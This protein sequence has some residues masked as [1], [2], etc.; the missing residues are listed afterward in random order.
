MK[1]I[2]GFLA[3][4]AILAG[5]AQTESAPGEEARTYSAHFVS[6]GGSAVDPVIG[7]ASGSLIPRP[8]DPQRSGYDFTE[9]DR[10]EGLTVPWNF[11]TDTVTGDVTLYAKWTRMN[12]ATLDVNAA[13][14]GLSPGFQDGDGLDAVTGNLSLATSAGEGVSVSWSS[15]APG[16]VT[17]DG[18]VTRPAEGSP[19][20]AVRLTATLEKDTASAQKTFDLTVLAMGYTRTYTLTFS[21]DGGSPVEPITDIASG[22]SVA[23]P[24]NPSK[25]GYAFAGWFT[26]AELTVALGSDAVLVSADLTLYAKWT[27]LAGNRVTYVAEGASPETVP[28]DTAFYSPGDYFMVKAT[29]PIREG[30]SFLGWNDAYDGSGANY[31]QY[32]YY[33]FPASGG[34]V[35]Y[36]QWRRVITVTYEAPDATEGSVP[37][38]A[39]AYYYPSASYIYVKSNT[40]FLYRDGYTLAGWTLTEDGIGTVYAAGDGVEVPDAPV[41]FYARWTEGENDVVYFPN[42]ATAGAV[43]VDKADYAAG[44]TVSWTSQGTLKKDDLVFYGWNTEADGTGTLVTAKDPITFGGTSIKLYAQWL[45]ASDAINLTDSGFDASANGFTW[46]MAYPD[47]TIAV[48]SDGKIVLGEKI[49]VDGAFKARILRLNA[50]GSLDAGFPALDLGFTG[51][52][53]GTVTTGKARYVRTLSDDRF[54]AYG[55]YYFVNG[56]PVQNWGNLFSSD[57]TVD[58]SY[59]HGDYDA[60]SGEDLSFTGSVY[61]F[62]DDSILLGGGKT[63]HPAEY[64][65]R[66]TPSGEVDPTFSFYASKPDYKPNAYKNIRILADSKFMAIE[67]L[68]QGDAD[69]SNDV[70]RI[71]RFT[72]DGS[73]D[74]S[75]APYELD[76]EN[77]DKQNFEV[78]SSG[79]VYAAIN[80]D[81]GTTQTLM[82]IRLTAAGTID[83]TYGVPSWIDPFAGTWTLL[84]GT[85]AFFPAVSLTTG[86]WSS[87]GLLTNEDGTI[88]FTRRFTGNP[89]VSVSGATMLNFGDLGLYAV[90]SSSIKRFNLDAIRN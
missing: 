45:E 57:G 7:L 77:A 51:Y 29:T 83:E 42:G 44:D 24:E 2:L 76:Q 13:K 52:P 74:A 6:N 10:D 34:V 64:F 87:S 47:S 32:Y 62:P 73:L 20:A 60:V 17:N 35:L 38:D 90:S 84:D 82:L 75:F 31:G 25:A 16:T 19:N 28:V 33:T 55:Y 39:N 11:E 12:Q 70:Y 14:E 89:G 46:N 18:T 49:Y 68:T 85:R 61:V 53:S 72:A 81:R 40:G 37:V 79:R 65:V 48:Q 58:S 78:D 66:V 43:P 15:D 26:D 30:Y 86:G 3:L 1:K 23:L 9:W 5:C 80:D 36:A 88:D 8:A 50:D 4:A 54:L 21:T 27:S 59:D 67:C 71:V 22:T 69:S 56:E 41:T 63:Y